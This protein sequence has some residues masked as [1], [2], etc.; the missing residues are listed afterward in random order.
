MKIA[1]ALVLAAAIVSGT[2]PAQTESST[3][4]HEFLLFTQQSGFTEP[5]R[6]AHRVV[7]AEYYVT[8]GPKLK[9]FGTGALSRRFDENDLSAGLGAYFRS[10]SGQMVYGSLTVGFSPV[11]IPR[12]DLTLEYTRLLARRLAGF[13]GYRTASFTGETVHMLIPGMTLYQLERW[14]FTPKVFL[15]RLASEATVH[16]TLFLHVSFEITDRLMP[17]LYYTV[18]SESYRAEALDYLASQHAWGITAG[19]KVQI[20]ER[21]RLRAH[22]QHVVR[23]GAFEENALD[24][25]LSFLW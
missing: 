2:A 19:A 25:A 16:A 4:A 13:L 12:T 17:E 23:T 21:L 14:T 24:A 8:A 7:S 9:L 15:A 11:V 6:S 20:S 22:Y 3:P 10:D 18:G 1:F 5:H